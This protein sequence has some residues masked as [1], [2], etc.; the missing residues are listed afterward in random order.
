MV[1]VV[2]AHMGP[3]TLVTP[4]TAQIRRIMHLRRLY[5]PYH[6]LDNRRPAYGACSQK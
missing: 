1:D 6:V 2:R 4:A 5:Y 3:F